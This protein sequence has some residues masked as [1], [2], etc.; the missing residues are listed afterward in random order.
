[1]RVRELTRKTENRSEMPSVSVQAGE[2]IDAAE[3]YICPE[4]VKY[5]GH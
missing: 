4:A 2:I 3:S 1:M 5:S